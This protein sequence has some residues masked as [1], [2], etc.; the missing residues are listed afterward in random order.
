MVFTL[1]RNFLSFSL[2]HF[3]PPSIFSQPFEELSSFTNLPKLKKP[4]MASF[5]PKSIIFPGLPWWLSGKE[6]TCQFRR[7]RF[8][9]RLR[10]IPWRRTWQ[11]TPVFLPGKSHGQRSLAGYSPWG[12]KRVWHDLATK[13]QQWLCAC[14]C[15]HALFLPLHNQCY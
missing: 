13:Q 4:Q 8:N 7:H 2:S 12:H 15:A 5:Q 6:S 9:P 3:Y 10:R 1:S 14:V 11:P